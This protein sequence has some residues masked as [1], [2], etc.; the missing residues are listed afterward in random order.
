VD[1]LAANIRFYNYLFL[2]EYIEKM[3]KD[4]SKWMNESLVSGLF[5]LKPS[6]KLNDKSYPNLRKYSIF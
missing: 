2:E 6:N 3:L 5:Y 1:V 4:H